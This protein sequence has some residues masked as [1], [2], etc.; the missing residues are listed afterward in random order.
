MW[1]LLRKYLPTLPMNPIPLES[2]LL[3]ESTWEYLKD[4]NLFLVITKQKVN[5]GSTLRYQISLRCMLWLANLL[6]FTL[7]GLDSRSQR[8]LKIDFELRRLPS[9]QMHLRNSNTKFY[10]IM[11]N[12]C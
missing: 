1:S 12:R 2:L 11:R 10:P 9:T 5:L 7:I 3:D 4:R 6:G 8:S